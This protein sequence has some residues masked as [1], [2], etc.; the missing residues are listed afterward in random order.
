[1]I[2]NIS[3][4]NSQLIPPF[5]LDILVNVEE[6]HVGEEDAKAAKE[7]P[8]VVEVVEVKEDARLVEMS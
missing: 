8:N 4:E 2:I 5:V 6:E 3:S 7:V 1:M